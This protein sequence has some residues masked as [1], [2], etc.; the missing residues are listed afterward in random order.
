MPTP[1]GNAGFDAAVL[2]AEQQ[3]QQAEAVALRAYNN[4][5]T[6]T[7]FSHDPLIV[8]GFP[9][10]FARFGRRAAVDFVPTGPVGRQYTASVND[11]YAEALRQ[12]GVA[13]MQA[14]QAAGTANNIMTLN[15]NAAL[16][17]IA[18]TGNP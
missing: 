6:G 12:A 3:Y 13:R 17:S 10:R 8:S 18:K 4:A 5:G 2:A 11:A 9:V 15:Q 14:I 16:T 7:S 1:V